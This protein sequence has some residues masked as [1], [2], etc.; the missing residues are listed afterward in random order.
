MYRKVRGGDIVA[1]VTQEGQR[2][3][4]RRLRDTGRSEMGR[5]S[6]AGHRKVRDGEIFGCMDR[7]VRDGDIVACVTQE[8]QRWGYRR[9]RDTGRSE[10]GRSSVAG[11]RK[12][13]DG[14]IFGCMDRKVRD[15]DIVACVTQ[16]GQ[17]WGYRR[18]RNTGRSE[19][20][21][22]SV[23]GHRKVRDGEIF[24]CGTQEGQ[25]W[26]DRRLRDT[27]SSR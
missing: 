14:E 7:K 19:M 20:G 11:H 9:L 22:S 5:S 2:W 26:G 21:R 15:G 24:G 25:R 13:R 10:M 17:R 27:G 6:V 12:V 3:G 1:C 8:G 16:E 23:A 18:L 4:Y